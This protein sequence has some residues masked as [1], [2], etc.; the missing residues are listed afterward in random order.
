MADSEQYWHLLET[1]HGRFGRKMNAIAAQDYLDCVEKFDLSILKVVVKQFRKRAKTLPTPEELEK[2][3]YSLKNHWE[4]EQAP[5]IHVCQYKSA[6]ESQYSRSLCTPVSELDASASAAMGWA[7][8]CGWHFACMQAKDA[9]ASSAARMVKHTLEAVREMNKSP[10]AENE[11]FL[12]TLGFN[13]FDPDPAKKADS[14]KIREAM[15]KIVVKMA[16][17]SIPL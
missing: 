2:A 9:P 5:A 1:L 8:M 6:L 3:C 14:S 17:N 16:S 15:G 11:Y 10:S 7:P 13:P 4:Q 12:R